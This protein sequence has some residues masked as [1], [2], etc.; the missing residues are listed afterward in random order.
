MEHKNKEND[1]MFF[2]LILVAMA[3]FLIVLV[4]FLT[5]TWSWGLM[6]DHTILAISGNVLQKGWQY[7]L[8]IL[9]HG[10]MRPVATYHAAITYKLFEN[11]PGMFHV[12]RFVEVMAAV[13]IW[14]VAAMQ[15]TRR[16]TA[17]GLTVVIAMTFHYVYDAFFFLSTQEILGVLLAG[18]AL[19]LIN[20]ALK[21][22]FDKKDAVGWWSLCAGL[23]LVLG[24]LGCKEPFLAVGTAFGVGFIVLAMAGRQRF[25]RPLLWVGVGL[26]LFLVS[27]ALVWKFL[28]CK[29]YTARYSLTNTAVLAGNVAG[30]AKKVLSNHLPWLVVTA[31]VW[32]AGLWRH[33]CV[34][35]YWGIGLGLFLYGGYLALILP[36]S[37]VAYM[38]TPLGVFFAFLM[39]MLLSR[40]L[41][42]AS[43]RV[44]AGVLL[45]GLVLGAG[46]SQYATTRE[47]LYHYDTQNLLV[48]IKDQPGFQKAAD[49]GFVL[50]N[51][52]EASLAIPSHMGR[53]WGVVIPRFKYVGELRGLQ[54]GGYFVYC[55]RFGKYEDPD[56]AGMHLVFQGKYWQVYQKR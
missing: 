47:M 55:P 7:F 14:A 10:A 8:D 50:C 43:R 29:G 1:H 5:Q 35:E 18:G 36:W 3:P 49:E 17:F 53:L 20:H 32:R 39:A 2:G 48:W 30:W 34:R 21:D 15:L 45:L 22:V 41:E 54:S 40:P 27:Y 4:S 56:F 44:T 26:L 6:D 42:M 13:M 9:A 33:F 28:I 19:V 25:H 16:K 31:V 46:V 24:A 51:A 11:A 37:A 38:S 52:S 23:L 12:F